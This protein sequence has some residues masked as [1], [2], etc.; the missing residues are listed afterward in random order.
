MPNPAHTLWQHFTELQKQANAHPGNSWQQ[1]WET[2]DHTPWE[3]AAGPLLSLIDQSRDIAASR[4]N[5][6]LST[7]FF[8]EPEWRKTILLTGVNSH[9]Q[10]LMSD[11]KLNDAALSGLYGV[12]MTIDGLHATLELADQQIEQ[13]AQAVQSLHEAVL[14]A[15]EIEPDLR[16]FLLH[17]VA[18]M[19]TRI[20]QRRVTGSGPIADLVTETIGSAATHASMWDRAMKS[21]LKNKVIAVFVALNAINGFI[22]TT[23]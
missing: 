13:L 6:E 14:A 2:V 9:Q 1:V 7:L 15:N 12:A 3:K 23:A 16:L 17:H 20:D 10:I 4:P 22:N 8:Y 19:Q 11:F 5:I 18:M 21:S